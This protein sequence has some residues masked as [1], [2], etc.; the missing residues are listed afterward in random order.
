MA[1]LEHGE[2]RTVRGTLV[3]WC[4]HCLEWVFLDRWRE[5]QAAEEVV[6]VTQKRKGGMKNG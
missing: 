2:K 4:A 1:G 6:H 3:Q 5:H